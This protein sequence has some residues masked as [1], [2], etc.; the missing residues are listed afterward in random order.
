M[1]FLTFLTRLLQCFLK[2]LDFLDEQGEVVVYRMTFLS[3]FL[4]GVEIGFLLSIFFKPK[5][6]SQLLAPR[7]KVISSAN[8]KLIIYLLVYS[9]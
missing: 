2:L 8:L 1:V 5:L 7:L 4:S 6:Y 3:A 9:Y